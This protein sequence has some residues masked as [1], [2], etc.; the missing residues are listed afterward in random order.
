MA[1]ALRQAAALND[2]EAE[3]VIL[4]HGLGRTKWSMRAIESALTSDGYQVWNQSYPS[5]SDTIEKLSVSH[6]D[7]GLS[8]CRQLKARRIHFVTHS[9]GGILVRSYLQN[10]QIHELGNIA[11]L[12]PPNKGSEVVDHLQDMFVFQWLLGP[13]AQELGTSLTSL[14]NQLLPIESTVGI[15]TGDNSS[16]P[17]FS[18]IIDGDDDGKVSVNS[19]KLDEMTDFLIVHRGHTFIMQDAFV[20]NEILVFLKTDRFTKS[21]SI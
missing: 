13:A 18:P 17:W 11:M 7:N 20:I 2:P 19:A 9:M 8:Y 16:D 4:L 6:I 14:P 12:S 15:I 10:H 1:D 5:T 3:C 21:P